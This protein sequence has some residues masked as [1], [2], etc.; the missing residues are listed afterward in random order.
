MKYNITEKLKTN[1]YIKIRDKNKVSSTKYDV[2][3]NSLLHYSLF[4][5]IITYGTNYETDKQRILRDQ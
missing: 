1:C 5:E 2:Y 4:E 3:P